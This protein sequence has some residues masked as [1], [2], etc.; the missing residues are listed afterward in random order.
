MSHRHLHSKD[1]HILLAFRW[2]LDEK[3]TNRD[4]LQ[5]WNSNSTTVRQHSLWIW[6]WGILWMKC[7]CALQLPGGGS[8]SL[9]RTWWKKSQ[10]FKTGWNENSAQYLR[11]DWHCYVWETGEY[12]LGGEWVTPRKAGQCLDKEHVGALWKMMRPAETWLHDV[13]LVFFTTDYYCHKD[14][15]I[16]THQKNNVL[17]ESETA[18]IANHQVGDTLIFPGHVDEIWQI[19]NL[20]IEVVECRSWAYYPLYC[21]QRCKELRAF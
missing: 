16:W 8:T 19:L 6:S 2:A 1:H 15:N 4:N 7:K 12:C 11:F 9:T 10:S 17:D 5:T 3:L 13:D 14:V 21:H 18:P 20:W